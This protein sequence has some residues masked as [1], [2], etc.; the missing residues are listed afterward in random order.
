[1]FCVL[2]SSN[3]E[4]I[5]LFICLFI[6][7]SYIYLQRDF[8]AIFL[9]YLLFVFDFSMCISKNCLKKVILRR[10]SL[11]NHIW[12]YLTLFGSTIKSFFHFFHAFLCLK[13][14]KTYRNHSENTNKQ[15]RHLEILHIWS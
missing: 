9:Y 1:M 14:S 8:L 12:Y 4:F 10:A 6:R 15:I 2:F 11:H 5:Y 3:F 7:H 13:S